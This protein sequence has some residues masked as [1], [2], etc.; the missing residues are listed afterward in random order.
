MASTIS[1][2]GKTLLISL[3]PEKTSQT[4]RYIYQMGD[5]GQIVKIYHQNI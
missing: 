3:T 1:S 4:V 2:L 5:E